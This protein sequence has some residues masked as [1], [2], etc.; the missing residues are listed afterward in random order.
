MLI[1]LIALLGEIGLIGYYYSAGNSAGVIGTMIVI[2]ITAV[3]L[4]TV[5]ERGLPQESDDS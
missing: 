3:A 2:A 1:L 4:A 5:Y